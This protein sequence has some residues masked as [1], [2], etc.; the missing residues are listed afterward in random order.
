[1]GKIIIK[2][3]LQFGKKLL[4]IPVLLLIGYLWIGDRRNIED[5]ANKQIED[6]Q[7]R[8]VVCTDNLSDCTGRLIMCSETIGKLL[9]ENDSLR[10]LLK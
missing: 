4:F 7:F 10:N 2:K 5:G 3:I 9:I 1:M 6:V 8:L